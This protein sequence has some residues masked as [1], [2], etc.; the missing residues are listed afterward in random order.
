MAFRASPGPGEIPAMHVRRG[1]WADLYACRRLLLIA[2]SLALLICLRSQRG[3]P[4]R[5]GVMPAGYMLLG[6]QDGM[7]FLSSI[8]GDRVTVQSLQGGSPREILRRQGGS[9]LIPRLTTKG[10]LY[11][12]GAAD[13]ADLYLLSAG[14]GPPQ[15]L[16]RLDVMNQ[17]KER[18][19]VPNVAI[20]GNRLFYLRRR[21]SG[22]NQ[23]Q[24]RK[25][26][27]RPRRDDL[28]TCDLVEASLDGAGSP[29]RRCAVA[30]SAWLYSAEDAVYWT[31]TDLL[32]PDPDRV[33]F[34]LRSDRSV[35]AQMPRYQG[36]S[37]PLEFGGRI[38]W[39]EKQSD[40]DS[41][42]EMH[43]WYGGPLP[44]TRGLLVSA[45]PD[46]SDRQ[47]HSTGV[48]NRINT[49]TVLTVDRGRLH[50]IQH[51]T[52]G[53]RVWR[54]PAGPFGRLQSI[55][56]A[57]APHSDS[58]FLQDGWLYFVLSEE[59]TNWFD[60]SQR[61]LSGRFESAIYRCRI[62]H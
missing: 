6:V 59:H 18:R 28:Q 22:T 5:L 2:V 7:L 60:W 20:V 34:S 26:H 38:Y 58:C 41:I 47:L 17:S 39:I 56:E 21:V 52:A 33:L 29:R 25:S 4:E 3:Q 9:A 48:L 23:A 49:S 10:L 37:P 57:R 61:G 44:P 54:L 53:Y 30:R 16:A 35:P 13:R 1:L 42:L 50:A 45:H 15:R 32:L 46:G 55:G 62:P 31:E 27:E 12:N 19:P 43:K 24:A 8:N 36:V 40:L 14:K 51:T 11:L